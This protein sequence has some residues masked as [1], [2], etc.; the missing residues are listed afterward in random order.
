VTPVPDSGTLRLGFEP[1]LTIERLPLVDPPEVGVNVTL[2]VV[3]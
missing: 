1:L 2:K 3:V